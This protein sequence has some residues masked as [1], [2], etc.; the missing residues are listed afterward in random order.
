MIIAID[1]TVTGDRIGEVDN[2][3]IVAG[4]HN[5]HHRRRI[6]VGHHNNHHRH[7]N[8]EVAQIVV[9][10]EIVT[11]DGLVVNKCDGKMTTAVAIQ[12]ELQFQNVFFLHCQ[13]SDGI[14]QTTIRFEFSGSTSH[15]DRR[16][17]RRGTSRTDN[18]DKRSGD[19]LRD[20]RDGSKRGKDD[21]SS[22]RSVSDF[23][24]FISMSDD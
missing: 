3:L 19:N 9:D 1:T 10:T 8:G 17:D 7:H 15:R 14:Q 4:P 24:N 21:H 20:K 22:G 2:R 18:R 6:V 12:G 23:L 16:D 13:Y 5:N 11:A